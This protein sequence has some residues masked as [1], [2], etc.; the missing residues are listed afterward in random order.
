MEIY[1]VELKLK[2]GSCTFQ[3][4]DITD[5][6]HFDFKHEW[7]ELQMKFNALSATLR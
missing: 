6:V 2:P 3:I 1:Q 7:N 4:V 5:Y